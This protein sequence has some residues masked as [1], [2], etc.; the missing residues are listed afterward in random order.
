MTLPITLVFKGNGN[1][2]LAN[3]LVSD[4]NNSTLVEGL[5]FKFAIKT[6]ADLKDGYSFNIYFDLIEDQDWTYFSKYVAY[7]GEDKYI[8][9]KVSK[10]TSENIQ[11]LK[12]LITDV[13]LDTH[14][15][16]ILIKREAGK[17]MDSRQLDYMTPKFQRK[18]IW[19]SASLARLYNIQIVFIKNSVRASSNQ[20]KERS[21]LNAVT[22]F[23]DKFKDSTKL[24]ITVENLYGLG[25]EQFITTDI[26]GRRFI[27]TGTTMEKLMTLVDQ[28]ISSSLSV[29]PLLK[30]VILETDEQFVFVD[31]QEEDV[32]GTIAASWGS[33][34]PLV[35]YDQHKQVDEYQNELK[36]VT[37]FL[38]GSVKILLGMQADI[39]SVYQK[40]SQPLLLWEMQRFHLRAFVDNLL[41]S[42]H[43]IKSTQ[44]LIDKIEYIVINEDIANRTNFAI[45]L[46]QKAIHQLETTGHLDVE[47]VSLAAQIAESVSNDPSL[48]SMLYFDNDAK[49]AVYLPIGMP[50]LLPVFITLYDMVRKRIGKKL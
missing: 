29:K 38:F 3:S 33:A 14:V 36:T 1:K 24:K 41:T 8:A 17:A 5:N 15:L 22:K 42:I 10:D 13:L 32:P 39:L 11:R 45:S 20:H 48:T 35:L 31:D 49:F 25:I 16:D 23:A 27:H 18:Y 43:H 44:A 26:S 28:H 6:S 7:L 2:D 47:T 19:E 4:L 50:I 37:S 46:I 34:I 21:I 9:V 30:L 40:S 12:A